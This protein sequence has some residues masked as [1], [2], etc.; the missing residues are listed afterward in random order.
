M[1]AAGDGSTLSSDDAVAWVYDGRNT[2]TG[3]ELSM[4]VVTAPSEPEH[5]AI[6]D[7]QLASTDRQKYTVCIALWVFIHPCN[8]PPC[9]ILCQ[10][11][12]YHYA[13]LDS[14]Y[15]LLSA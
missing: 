2:P 12:H 9:I 10:P 6:I 3:S 5:A 8:C 1:E 4:E 14:R 11:M 13:K 7:S 15:A